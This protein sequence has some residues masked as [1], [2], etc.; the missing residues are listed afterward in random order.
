MNKPER[1]DVDASQ[2]I[3]AQSVLRRPVFWERKGRGRV[4]GSLKSDVLI[5]R[6]RHQG[7]RVKPLDGDL[8]SRTLATL[9]PAKDE[10]D[11]PFRD[12][13][14]S[15]ASEELSVMKA[16]L[17]NE[18]DQMVEDQVSRVLDL[19]GGDRV[20]QEFVRDLSIVS[21]CK[22]FGIDYTPMYMLGP[23]LEDFRHVIELIRSGEG[24]V[25]RTLLVMNE[26][27]IRQ[28]QSAEGVFNPIAKHPEMKSLIRDGVRIVYLRRLTCIDLVRASGLGYY[29]IAAGVPGANGVR[30]K[31]TLQH[32]TKAWLQDM[33][34]EHTRAGTTEWL[35]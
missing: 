26:G 28:G 13:A 2:K 10:N 6:G 30:P 11:Q 14:S 35:P 21:Y 9:Y 22:E 7:R 19:G 25:Q 12:G 29:D 31:A 5:Q 16:W 23:D 32:M 33:E 15:P 18:L 8:R 1:I 3:E 24:N 34:A 20:V 4:G 17:M 27:V